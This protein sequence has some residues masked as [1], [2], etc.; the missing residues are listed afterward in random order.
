[1]HTSDDY[2][3]SIDQLDKADPPPIPET[4]IFYLAAVCLN[5]IADGLAGFALP[6]FAAGSGRSASTSTVKSPTSEHARGGASEPSHDGKVDD[7]DSPT[8]AKKNLALITDMANTA[9]PGLL[10]AMSFFLSANLD[11]ELFQSTMRSYQN[12]TNV[13]G[14]L[15]LVVPRDAFLTNLCK[16][17]VPASPVLS[18]GLLSS[19]ST[20]STTSITTVSTPN[21]AVSYSDLPV[22]QQQLLSSITLSDR[23]LYS[24]RVLLN[25]AMFL[26]SV[27]GP[28]WYLILET[29]EQ[30]DFLLFNRPNPKGAGGSGGQPSAVQAVRR[31][32]PSSSN[33]SMTSNS[34]NPAQGMITRV[35][36]CACYN[37]V[38]KH[39]PDSECKSSCRCGPC[40]SY[41]RI[42]ESTV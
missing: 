40:F 32:L 15:D 22:Q 7:S 39:R 29:L 41:P 8:S 23:N 12:F 42:Y 30:A 20:G 21:L 24:L 9:W 35:I 11:E 31:T 1:M 4:Y 14:V 28:S 10:A 38:V 19:K 13:C 37:K 16:N 26:G 6:R 36:I 34:P 25:I 27:L 33:A 17:A 5:S 18:S 2:S 3:H